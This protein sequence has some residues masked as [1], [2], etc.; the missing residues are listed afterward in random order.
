MKMRTVFSGIAGL[1]I[2]AAVLLPVAAGAQS[3]IPGIDDGPPEIFMEEAPSVAVIPGTY[4]YFVPDLLEDIFFYHGRW[5]R[6]YGGRW[7]W[8]GSYNGPWHHLRRSGVPS[9]ILNLPGD[10]RS[11]GV[12]ER[13]HHDHFSRNWRDWERRKHWNKQDFWQRDRIRDHRDH[14]RRDDRSDRWRDDRS[15]RW[16][17]DRSD[18]RRDDRSDRRRDDRSDRRRDDRGT[19]GGGKQEIYQGFKMGDAIE[20]KNKGQG[21]QDV[22]QGGQGDRSKGQ[23]QQGVKQGGQ[24]DKRGGK[25]EIYQGF[26]M[27]DAIEKNKKQGQNQ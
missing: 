10:Y 7:Y 21:Q 15:D 17:D 5:Y 23:G 6:P 1:L 22:K 13:I 20:K 8:G 4:V 19:K 2:M 3:V 26:K 11:W 25:Q 9:Y 27:G 24:G 12:H 18:R 16:R 14:N